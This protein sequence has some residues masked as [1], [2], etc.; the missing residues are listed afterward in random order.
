MKIRL[1]M[2][3]DKPFSS[4]KKD[5]KY[6][7]TESH[8]TDRIVKNHNYFPEK[9]VGIK[10]Y[11]TFASANPETRGFDADSNKL[12]YGVMVTLQILVLSFL[13][14]VRVPQ[15]FC[16]LS[17]WKS[18]LGGFFVNILGVF[19]AWWQVGGQILTWTFRVWVCCLPW[20]STRQSGRRIHTFQ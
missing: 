11:C 2:S 1:C 13:V 3:S 18:V 17:Y 5:S 19:L 20:C 7:A 14:R 15:Q 10:K 9:F 4:F 12:G 6:S 8:S 16:P